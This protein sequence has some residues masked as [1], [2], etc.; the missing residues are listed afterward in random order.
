MDL[1]SSPEC[2]QPKGATVGQITTFDGMRLRYA[3]W[4]TT[5]KRGKG[6]VCVFPG[7]GEF[8]EKYYEV[9]SELRE[10][11]FAV[12]V[13]D[14]RGQGGSDRALKNPRISHVD[15][16]EDYERD[17]RRYMEEIVLPDCPAPYYA[18]AHSM[19]GNI[20]LRAARLGDCWFD[21]MV[22][23]SPMVKI[24]Q[25]IRF[26]ALTKKLA[27]A[28]AFLGLGSHFVPGGSDKPMECQ[29]FPGNLL[30][31]D[32]VRLDRMCSIVEAVPHL[33]LGSPS[34]QWLYAAFQTTTEIADPDFPET[35]KVPM[36]LFG[37]GDDKI[38]SVKAIEQLCA[39]MRVGS[40]MLL[41]SARHEIL[42]EQDY[43]REQF[44]AA[45]DAFIPG[46]PVY[47]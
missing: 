22:L 6:T 38:V 36:L 26:P 16:F 8:I 46:S 18:L 41:P 2:P 39:E 1:Y 30:T 45:F 19:G 37:A 31:S 3:R 7:R 21:R 13:L 29:P 11:G 15:D 12:A 33:A 4:S 40:F 32:E 47:L 42:M 14:W 9:V 17:L 25:G 35:V 5:A 34:I 43:I 10:R 23:V 27:E 44:W 24:I 28:L 20:L